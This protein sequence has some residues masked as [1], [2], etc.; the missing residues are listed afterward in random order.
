MLIQTSE[1]NETRETKERLLPL[2]IVL[3]FAPNNF[4]AAAYQTLRT[5]S[6]FGREFSDNFCLCKD[7]LLARHRSSGVTRAMKEQLGLSSFF[8]KHRSCLSKH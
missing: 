4:R 1:T 6:P 3:T 8:Q 7:T 5:T 2:Y